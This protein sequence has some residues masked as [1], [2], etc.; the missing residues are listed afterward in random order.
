MQ[1]KPAR[2]TD[3]FAPM[4][5]PLGARHQSIRSSALPTFVLCAASI[6]YRVGNS[7][8]DNALK[9]ARSYFSVPQTASVLKFSGEQVREPQPIGVFASLTVSEWSKQVHEC[10]VP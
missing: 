1:M 4:G 9:Y 8:Y 3:T 10:K 7:M 6:F 5:S 2:T